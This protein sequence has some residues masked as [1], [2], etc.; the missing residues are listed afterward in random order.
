MRG[1]SGLEAIGVAREQARETLLVKISDGSHKY[2]TSISCQAVFVT[3]SRS[4]SGTGRFPVSLH[5]HPL[6]LSSSTVAPSLFSSRRI[7]LPPSTEKPNS[8]VHH[9]ETRCRRLSLVQSR[10]DRPHQTCA[11]IGVC[12]VSNNEILGERHQN[13][14]QSAHHLSGFQWCAI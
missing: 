11:R 5:V 14:V 4:S 2:M 7:A 3:P 13:L 9:E 8:F 10:W 6:A 1:V 12:T